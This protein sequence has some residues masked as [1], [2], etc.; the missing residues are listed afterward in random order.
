MNTTTGSPASALTRLRAHA[1]S[2]GGRVK[3]AFNRPLR[4][5]RILIR[6]ADRRLGTAM[7]CSVSPLTRLRTHTQPA[8]KRMRKAFHYAA[9]L[10][11]I[12]AWRADR[13]LREGWQRLVALLQRLDGRPEMQGLLLGTFAMMSAFFL[14]TAN[15][16]T[17]EAIAERAAEDLRYSLSQ[18]VP[19]AHH[20][21]NLASDVGELHDT[22]EGQISFH[23]A[24]MDKEVVAVAF[25]MISQGYAGS[26]KVLLGIDTAGRLLGVRV[27]SHA[28]TPGLGDKIEK[29]KSNWILGFDGLSLGNPPASMWKVKKDG[30]HFDQFSGATVT[31]RAVVAAISR[32]LQV[33]LRNRDRFLGIAGKPKKETG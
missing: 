5:L 27:L 17:R 30:G 26:I 31:P 23:R 20:N 28:E 22:R 16:G 25:E 14:A 1:R 33:F 8:G 7:G 10:L 24:R 9:R 11:P 29:E 2:V 13:R 6:R 21:N 12:I 32:G 18:V 15:L 19:A 3:K 4:I